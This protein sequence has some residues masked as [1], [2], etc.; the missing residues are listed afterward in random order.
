MFAVRVF[1]A[2]SFACAASTLAAAAVPGQVSAAVAQSAPYVRT[3]PTPLRMHLTGNASAAYRIVD[4]GSPNNIV[5]GSA[6]QA[7]NNTGQIVGYAEVPTSA[8]TYKNDCV[9]WT[10]TRFVDMSPGAASLGCGVVGLRDASATSKAYVITGTV[11]VPLKDSAVG[12]IAS[13]TP[14]STALALTTFQGNSFSSIVAVNAAGYGY[15]AA[16]YAPPGGFFDTIPPFVYSGGKLSPMQPACTTARAGC[17]GFVS[18]EF[19]A[20]PFGKCWMTEAGTILAADVATND[21]ALFTN[22]VVTPLPLS[23]TNPVTAVAMNEAR[24]IAYWNNDANGEFAAVYDVSKRT[25]TDLGKLAGTGCT[26]YTPLSINNKTAVLGQATGCANGV[27]RLWLWDPVRKMRDL[28][29]LVPANDFL[30]ISVVGIND[31]GW[32]LVALYPA[33]GRTDWGYLEPVTP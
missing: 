24:Q 25:T 16:W 14:A 22:G 4:L 18:N 31:A 20:C 1:C 19:A 15:G 8:T 5:D 30:E 11:N 7:F 21:L 13:G 33:G 29:T 23:A 2:A 9:V 3:T 28:S 10:G 32:I 27:D 17:L 6:P 26:T 12:F